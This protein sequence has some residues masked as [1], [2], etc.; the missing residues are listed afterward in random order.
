ML[1][2][3]DYESLDLTHKHNFLGSI[4]VVLWIAHQYHL[5][6]TQ[7]QVYVRICF[8][9]LSWDFESWIEINALLAI[10]C[11][12][13]NHFRDHVILPMVIF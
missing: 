9:T 5:H 8:K 11:I 12:M 10:A 7:F 4:T 1:L 2:M 13:G 3:G 6:Q